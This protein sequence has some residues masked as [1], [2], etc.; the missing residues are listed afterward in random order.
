MS[1]AA[2]A[3][4]FFGQRSSALLVFAIGWLSGYTL[5]GGD[6]KLPP[7]TLLL[8]P[9]FAQTTAKAD[10]PPG[11]V[12]RIGNGAEPEYVDPELMSGNPDSRVGFLLF[13]GLTITDDK[14]LQPTRSWARGD[15]Q[16]Q[17]AIA[18]LSLIR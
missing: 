11:N 12:F 8:I 9:G 4:Q 6:T 18:R 13:E 14:S 3:R 7:V 1:A 15:F 17:L 10:P 16:R 5:R 2:F